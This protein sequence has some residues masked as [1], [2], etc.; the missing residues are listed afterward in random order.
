MSRLEGEVESMKNF[1]PQANGFVSKS[2]PARRVFLV[3]LLRIPV[4]VFLPT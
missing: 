1:G 2:N 3:P 4:L